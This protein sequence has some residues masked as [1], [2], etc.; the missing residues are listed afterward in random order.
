FPLGRDFTLMLDG[1]IRRGS[2]VIKAIGMGANGIM[3]G[4]AYTFGLA[5][6]GRAGVTQAIETLE[7]EIS[8]TLSLMGC[9]SIDDLMKRGSHFVF[10]QRNA[11]QEIVT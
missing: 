4:R 3:L 5:A 10:K 6:N 11:A 7:R 9:R 8:I 1:G 2:D